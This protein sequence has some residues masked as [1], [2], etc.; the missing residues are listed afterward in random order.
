MVAGMRSVGGFMCQ[1][2]GPV[3]SGLTNVVTWLPN[4]QSLAGYSRSE[5]DA[6]HKCECEIN[7]VND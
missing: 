7:A 3:N 1:D 5:Q 2:S 6:T 4:Q